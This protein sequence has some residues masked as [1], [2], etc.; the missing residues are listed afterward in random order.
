MEGPCTEEGICRPSTT[1]VS[2][3][4]V[5]YILVGSCQLSITNI[6]GYHIFPEL[7][8]ETNQFRLDISCGRLH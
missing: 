3:S 4:G 8:S 2:V 5:M 7:H 6:S 1:R